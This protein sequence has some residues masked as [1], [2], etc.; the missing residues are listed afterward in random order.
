MFSALIFLRPRSIFGGGPK[1]PDRPPLLICSIL[2]ALANPETMFGDG[3]PPSRFWL[4]EVGVVGVTASEA[5]GFIE[6]D[7]RARPE[8]WFDLEGWSII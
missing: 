1:S 3:A 2:G 4:P 5:P 8:R 6:R 7:D